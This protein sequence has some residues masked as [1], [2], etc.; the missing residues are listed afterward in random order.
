VAKLRTDIADRLGGRLAEPEDIG[1]GLVVDVIEVP[2]AFWDGARFDSNRRDCNKKSGL[3][4]GDDERMSCLEVEVVRALRGNAGWHAGWVQAGS[5]GADTWGKW[6]WKQLPPVVQQRNEAVQAVLEKSPKTRGGHPDVALLAGGG[7]L[8]LECMIFDD[9]I[10]KQVAWISAA[11]DAGVVAIEDVMLV[12]GVTADGK[13]PVRH[14]RRTSSTTRRAR[15]ARPP[16]PIKPPER[17]AELNALLADAKSAEP[18]DRID[19]QVSIAT[20]GLAGVSAMEEWI[21]QGTMVYFAI[22]VIERVGRSD[23]SGEAIRSLKR[24]RRV[25]D[26]DALREVDAAISRLKPTRKTTKSKRGS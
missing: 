13:S 22:S 18:A 1:G 5:C 7:V 9:K 25:V 20:W 23:D 17:P 11:V 8:Y 12:Q 4:A 2:I 3:L 19:F 15:P 6:I 16:R 24:A 26:A 14:R 10:D 21:E